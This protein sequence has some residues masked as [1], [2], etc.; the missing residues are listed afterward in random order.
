MLHMI[1]KKI[2][3]KMWL[4]LCLL[5]GMAFLVAVF[6]CQPMF[7]KGSLNMLLNSRFVEVIEEKNEY[8]VVIGRV[9]AYNA[10]SISDVEQVVS[11][12]ERYH[13]TWTGYLTDLDVLAKQTIIYMDEESCQGSYGSKGNYLKITYMPEI[14]EH[15]QLL[16]GQGLDEQQTNATGT[17]N[18]IIT[19]T[20]MDEY[21]LVVGE[22][23][24]FINLKDEK[25]NTLKMTI[26]GVYKESER[27]DLYWTVEPNEFIENV[28]VDSQSFSEIVSMYTT[29]SDSYTVRYQHYTSLDYQDISSGNVDDVEYYMKE[30]VSADKNF[31]YS[32]QEIID[33][34]KTERK[35]VNIILWVLELPILG[36][37]MAFIFMVSKQIVEAERNEIAMHRSRGLSRLQIIYMYGLQAG[38]ISL[39]GIIAGLPLSYILC[40]L[41]AGT[42]DFLTFS[43]A[44][45]WMYTF[46]PEMLLYGVVAGTIGI[47][48]ILVPV[49][50]ATKISIVEHKSQGGLNKKPLWEKY[51][52][53]IILLA[54]SIYLLYNFNQDEENIRQN[55]IAG[56]KMDP[57]IFIDSVLFIIGMGLVVLRL[58]HYLVKLVYRIGKKKWKPSMYAS[59]LQITR[60]TAK[61]GFISV[62]LILTVS[63]GLFNAN[64]A[65]TINRNN[66]DRIDYENGADLVLQEKWDTKIFF[67]PDRKVDYEFKEPDYN[68]YQELT[69]K[70]I[71][72]SITRVIYDDR[73]NVSYAGKDIDNCIFR[74]VITDEFGKTAIF[75]DELNK[76]THWYNY[77]NAMA[78][79]QNGAV[80]SSNLAKELELEV[81]D[82]FRVTRMGAITQKENDV[83][84]TSVCQ[85]CAIVEDWPGYDRYYYDENGDLQENYLVVANYATAVSCFKISPYE[86]WVKIAEGYTYEDVETFLT[87]K[88][89]DIE[90]IK[91][92]AEDVSRMKNSPMIQITNGMFTLS[93]VIAL[94]LCA[95]GFLIYWISSIR[96]REL[97]FGVYR[98]MG[99]S[100]K[101][102]N[103]ML[104]NEH[105]FSTFLSVIAGG[106]VGM[107]S[108]V[109]F[110]KL[111]GIVYL[112]EKHNLDIYIYYEAGDIIKLAT[113]VVVMIIVCILVLRKLIKSLNITQ[114]LKLGE[115]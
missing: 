8:P 45:T 40:K 43:F 19:Q 98:A 16:K 4:T 112:P 41:A 10:S 71:C 1:I 31:F 76:D 68:K 23:L 12:V 3:N 80:I 75:K 101:D 115:E 44:R 38:I 94:I 90:S 53:D 2:K 60:T 6:A 7:K 89:V 56:S 26:A 91:I 11:D 13:K 87:N 28:F 25:G 27:N 22:T 70:G 92:I 108:T 86:I 74:G 62:F 78:V 29:E 84:G 52:F 55:A 105:I 14:S 17:Y 61:Q 18:C 77:L 24:D 95:I 9:G 15:M 51:F 5:L 85:V 107:V 83:R 37:V 110:V 36:M 103:G 93:F 69:D 49:I 81:G 100:V 66:E 79:K 39:L 114:A 35:T 58:T 30:F 109:L 99:M 88:S 33:E 57:M 20:L 82:T 47:G 21:G 32:F 46:T 59:F 113:V 54:V 72:E 106:L 67:L 97:L 96:Q 50:S 111:F 102:V 34:F 65:R 73:T 42:T 63:L 104:I 64:T 48:F